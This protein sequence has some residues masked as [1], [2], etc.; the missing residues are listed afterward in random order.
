MAGINYNKPITSQTASLPT[1]LWT[2]NGKDVRQIMDGNSATCDLYSVQIPWMNQELIDSGNVYVQYGR[3]MNRGYN[4]D[5]TWP[6]SKRR[7]KFKPYAAWPNNPFPTGSSELGGL[8][9]GVPV[10]AVRDNLF[11]VTHQNQ[12]IAELPYWSFY[13][14]K[15]C[16]VYTGDIN[17]GNSGLIN[18]MLPTMA[19]T[20]R[21]GG[22]D[23]SY[24]QNYMPGGSR[25][26]QRPMRL[27]TRGRFFSNSIWSARLVL[28]V[29][30]KVQGYGPLSTALHIKP[31]E[32][33]YSSEMQSSSKPNYQSPSNSPIWYDLR[34][35]HGTIIDK[36]RK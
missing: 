19:G 12:I 8:S 2:Y 18:L 6:N 23:I 31:N 21:T 15:N 33:G 35:F 13:I 1:P 9:V 25:E 14:L 22:S 17:N 24:I 7:P 34:T 30:G 32:M 4:N 36:Y 29:D 20:G 27:M 26:N 5:R 11:K 28:I 10:T 16:S 3:Y